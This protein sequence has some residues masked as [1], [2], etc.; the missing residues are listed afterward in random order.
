MFK[1]GLHIFCALTQLVMGYLFLN[2]YIVEHNGFDFFMVFWCL[3]FLTVEI[4]NII[5][6]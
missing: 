4:I 5:K 2:R 3:F 1:L 6:I